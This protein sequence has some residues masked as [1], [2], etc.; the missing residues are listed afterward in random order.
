MMDAQT[1]TDHLVGNLYFNLGAV[2]LMAARLHPDS[3]PNTPGKTVYREMCRLHMG[4]DTRL[5]PGSLESA[6]RSVGFD[7]GY[8][9]DLQARVMPESVEALEEYA[10]AINN[11]ADLEQL[12]RELAT[13]IEGSAESGATAETLIP[14][15]MRRMATIQRSAG[16]TMRHISAVM[17]DVL[18]DLGM[19]E[20]G[21]SIEGLSTGFPDLDKITRLNPGELTLMA[22]RPSM[23][24]TALAMAIAENV[25]EAN[26]DGVVVVFSAEMTSRSLGHRMVSSRATVNGHRLRT[27]AADGDEYGAAK[28]AAQQLRNL[29]ILIDE[30]ASITTEQMY[31]RTAMVNAQTP[32]KLVVFDFVELGS[33]KSEKRSDSEEQRI[34]Q[35]ARGLKAIAKNLNVPVLALS[36]LNRDCEKRPDKLPSLA[37]LRY[38]GML[39]QIADVVT[40][41]MRPEYY[42]AR[43]M[44]CYLDEEVA[45]PSMGAAHPHAQGVAYVMVAKNRNGPVGRVN[46]AYVSKYTKFG[47]LVQEVK[48]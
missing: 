6:L 13:A 33:D 41:I 22:A 26:P 16:G 42:I 39:E 3:L 32:V 23:G 17:D 7:F 15:I 14:D 35:I 36:Q 21:Q 47:S 30:S 12:R 38:S 1:A 37:D 43:Q 11:A 45:P 18:N 5:S 44:R 34:S 8:I 29:S 10:D 4:H 46:L 40:F 25:A 28:R 19:W 27:K 31:Y 24:K 48:R 9:S 2:P 20:S